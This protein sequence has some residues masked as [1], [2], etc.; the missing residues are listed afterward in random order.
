MNI[1][2]IRSKLLNFRSFPTALTST[3]FTQCNNLTSPAVK[4]SLDSIKELRKITGAPISAVKKALEE[5][6]GDIEGAIDHLRK[7][8][9]SL[10][11]KKANRQAME[12]LVTISIS[13]DNSKAVILELNSETD[14]VARTPQF[15]QLARKLT[16]SA[17][18]NADTLG[19]GSFSHIDVEQLLS[20]NDNK[21]LISSAVSS[22]GE[23]I[24][25]KRATSMNT[26]SE[27]MSIFGYVHGTVAEQSG[28][29]GVLA[30]LDG[31]SLDSIGPRVAMHIAAAAPLY[32]TIDSVPESDTEKELSI[33]LEAAR[34]EQSK[35]K[36]KPP[37]VLQ[38]IADGRL[39]KWYSEVVLNEQEMLVENPSYEG[40]P[41]SVVKSLAAEGSGVR[42]TDFVRFSTGNKS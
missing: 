38:K 11:A 12:G 17:L 42:I 35:G 9:A 34:E 20:I 15:G 21:D 30:A 13:A 4:V 28:K 41:R 26:M 27:T 37:E 8:G 40:K 24:V 1:T 31:P 32:P 7:L 29:I 33:L 6:N 2:G 39:K 36:P 19:V 16:D 3:N 22:L 23:N 14:F 18:S 25:L 5:Q 10:V